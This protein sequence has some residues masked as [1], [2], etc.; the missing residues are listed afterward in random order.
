MNE[1]LNET[2]SFFQDWNER[3]DLNYFERFLMEAL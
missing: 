2:K 3:K 1:T